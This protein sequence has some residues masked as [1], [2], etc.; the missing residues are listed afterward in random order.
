VRGRRL[1]A[2]ASWLAVTAGAV[3]ARAQPAPPSAGEQKLVKQLEAQQAD[4]EEQGARIK[5]LEKQLKA[6]LAKQKEAEKAAPP[7][8]PAPSPPPPPPHPAASPP[9]DPWSILPAFLKDLTISAYVQAQYENHQDAQDQIDPNGAPLNTDRF[10]LR[11]GRIKIDRQWQYASTMIE[12][13]GNTVNGPSFNLWHAE[14]SVLYRGSRAFSAPPI[15]QLTF[16]QFDTPFGFELV[17]SPKTRWFMERSLASRSLWPGEPDLGARISSALGWFRATVAVLNGSPVGLKTGFPLRDPKAFKDIVAR[18]GADI[19]P[20]PWLNIAG[21]ASVYNGRGFHPG[22]QAGKTS[23]QWKDTNEDG[24]IEATEL[25]P[26]SATT[27]TPSQT[28]PRWAVGGDLRVT[29]TTPIGATRI[30]G[31]VVAA[32]NMDRVLFIAD[33]VL[34]GIDNREL[35]FMVGFSQE[36]F[37]YGVIGFRYDSYDPNG[38]AQDKQGGKL[39]PSSQTVRVFSPMC[40]LALPE[41]A[42]LLFQYDVNRNHLGRDPNGLPSNLASDVITLRLQGVL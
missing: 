41:R 27:S 7:A 9:F 13:D 18:A 3:L 39:L 36:I 38:D 4:L 31:E 5:E 21:G 8:G 1:A 15:L 6:L 2:F 30:G 16:G 26:V 42:R 11:R 22:A 17:E 20:V 19:D 24:I 37:G 35:G 14:A 10:V 32:S 23:I 29:F 28:F 12:L 34:T 33:P 40:G 25:I